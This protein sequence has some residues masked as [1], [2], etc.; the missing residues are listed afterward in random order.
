MPD[1]LT[2]T[3]FLTHSALYLA[4]AILLPLIFHAMGP[5]GRVFLPMHIPILLAGFLVGPLSGLLVGLLAPA[6]SHLMTGLPPTYAVPLMSAELPIYGLI[7]GLAYRKLRM[8]IYV[9]L[10]AAMLL[11]RVM[12]ALSLIVLGLFMDIPYTF[13]QYLAG[14]AM[15]LVSLPGILIQLTLLPLLVAAVRRSKRQ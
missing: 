3:R 8:N 10:L 11:G 5:G 2:R 13:T 14:G 15:L 7:A 12:F 4:L 6:L 9:S 1:S